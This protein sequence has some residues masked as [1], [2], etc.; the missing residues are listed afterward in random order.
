M[1][2]VSFF[3]Y[4][5]LS[6]RTKSIKFIYSEKATKFCESSTLLLSYGVQV[7]SKVEIFHNFVAFS[8]YMNFSSVAYFTRARI[9][10]TQS[11]PIRSLSF[12]YA[13]KY[14]LQLDSIQKR[15]YFYEEVFYFFYGPISPRLD[16]EVRS[17]FH[18]CS[19]KLLAWPTSP[20]VI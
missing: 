6:S 5:F 10:K 3:Q 12:N 9:E 8:E 13:A 1:Y 4:Q 19:D 18:T 16:N 15:A 11:H 2:S 14:Q 7:K 20:S 17:Q